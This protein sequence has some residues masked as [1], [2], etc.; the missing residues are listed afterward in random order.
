MKPSPKIS[1]VTVTY[2]SAATLEETI[3]SVLNQTYHNIEYII[4]DGGSTDGTVDIIKK[5]ADR[6]AYWISE[7]DSGMYDAL[8][9]GFK[10]ATGDILC[11]LNADDLF[12]K[13]ALSTVAD[14]FSQNQNI[15][16]VKGYNVNYNEKSQITSVSVPIH[17]SNK[18]LKRGFYQPKF[19]MPFIQQESTFWR[20]T[21]MSEVDIEKFKKFKLAGDYFLWY[22]FSDKN[23]LHFISSYLGGWRR[24]KGQLSSNMTDYMNEVNSFVQKKKPIDYLGCVYQKLIYSLFRGSS[25]YT[26]LFRKTSHIWNITE[27]RFS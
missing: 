16:W 3:L 27:E 24:V 2:N 10:K 23:E 8:S 19:R 17:I 11:W 26:K 18:L 14:F 22:S 13:E 1:V 12:Y 20:S 5:Y 25:L 4:I 15:N 7:P 9:K 21:L 6:F